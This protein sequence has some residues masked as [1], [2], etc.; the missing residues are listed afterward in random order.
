MLNALLYYYN[1]T[2]RKENLLHVFAKDARYPSGADAFD[3]LGNQ[4]NIEGS[5]YGCF[6]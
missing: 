4:G 1:N 6:N 2:R 5:I 3:W